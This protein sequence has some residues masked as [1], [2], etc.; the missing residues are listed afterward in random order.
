VPIEEVK[1]SPYFTPPLP[2]F[3]RK[4]QAEQKPAIDLFG[5]PIKPAAPKQE[6][7]ESSATGKQQALFGKSG[8]PGQRNLFADKGVPEDLVQ[9]QPEPKGDTPWTGGEIAKGRVYNI[10]TKELHV[11]PER[12]QFKIHVNKE[13]VTDELKSVRKW[14]PDFAG[15]LA[16]W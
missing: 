11:D 5:E 16:V 3:T 4:P 14:N 8:Q 1:A 6:P 13:G 15:V 9:K 12:F 2:S 7:I 10:P